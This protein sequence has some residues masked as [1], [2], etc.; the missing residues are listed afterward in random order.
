[1][2]YKKVLLSY[3]T[4]S[5][6]K[7]VLENLG[8]EVIPTTIHRNISREICDHADMQIAKICEDLFVCSPELYNY[9]KPILNKKL[10]CG[11]TSLKCN[12]PYDI[13]YNIARVGGYAFHNIKYTDSYV[14]NLLK[15]QGVKIVNVSQGY[16]KCNMCI[17]GNAVI[18]S[19]EGIYQKCVSL[20]IRTLKIR[21]GHITLDGYDYGFIGG[22]SGMISNDTVFFAGDIESHPDFKEIKDFLYAVNVK[23]IFVPN[24][25]LVDIGSV[26]GFGI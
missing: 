10:M 12:Y 20:G 8:V 26:I 7:E 15:N 23:F 2:Y 1:M 3:K 21:Q 9:Y 16:T 18:T 17:V 24:T 25:P 22:A 11:S 13:A 4:P 14:L 19:D 6:V 5:E